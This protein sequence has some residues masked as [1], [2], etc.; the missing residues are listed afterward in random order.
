M[1]ETKKEIQSLVA[2]KMQ[3]EGKLT[4]AGGDDFSFLLDDC[5]D[6]AGMIDEIR[7]VSSKMGKKGHAGFETKVKFGRKM[8]RKAKD[9]NHFEQWLVQEYDNKHITLEHGKRMVAIVKLLRSSSMDKVEKA[10]R[11][12]EEF[13]GF[14]GM[15]ARLEIINDAL[16]KK[17][18]QF[19]REKRAVSSKM[20]DLEWL[21][22]EIA[23]DAEK[24]ARHDEKA[25]LEKELAALWLECVQSLKSMPLCGLLK[26]MQEEKL[27]EVGFPEIAANDA[28]SMAAF[29]HKNGLG[30]KSAGQLFEMSGQS[31]QRL[32]HE[33]VDLAAFRSQV[34]ARRS[35]LSGIMSAQPPDSSAIGK[36]RPV[37]DYLSRQSEVAQK[38]A[39]RLVV[40][41]RTTDEDEGE[42]IRA[43]KIRQKKAELAGLEKSAL[44][45]SL[46]ELGEMERLLDGKVEPGKR[47]EAKKGGGIAGFIREL[48]K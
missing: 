15:G 23:P 3:I 6:L 45:G 12:A 46:L 30:S 36:N 33:G 8:R 2:E 1:D 10:A 35:F 43:E 9:L 4:S 7:E 19:E 16:S 26:K 47:E 31:E 24:V 14:L 17:R 27:Y 28:E 39:E 25:R 48:L 29:L 5:A 32:R 38:D 22:K 18:A 21:E 34:V 44:N 40:L 37:L 42:W 11:E 13:Y 41:G 20:S